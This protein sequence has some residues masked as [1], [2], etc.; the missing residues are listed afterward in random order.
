MSTRGRPWP[1]PPATRGGRRVD[2]RQE[3]P[4]ARREPVADRGALGQPELLQLANVDLERQTRRPE[5]RRQVCGS[6]ARKLTDRAQHG[7]RPR[8]VAAGPIEPRQP[9]LERFDLLCLR[10]GPPQRASRVR[11]GEAQPYPVDGPL[12]PIEQRQH[13]VQR[14]QAGMAGI[15][16]VKGVPIDR[17]DRVEGDHPDRGTL[18]SAGAHARRRPSANREGHPA[19][20]DALEDGA[21]EQHPAAGLMLAGGRKRRHASDA[22]RRPR[23][24][25]RSPSGSSSRMPCALPSATASAKRWTGSDPNSAANAPRSIPSTLRYPSAMASKARVGSSSVSDPATA[26]WPC[27]ASP[28]YA[29][30]SRSFQERTAAPSYE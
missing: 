27:S 25:S 4:S 6:H 12:S 20:A 8:P 1:R 24:V 15:S 22:R 16:L 18:P 23:E 14:A 30:R 26:R 7:V 28:T 2:R 29:S 21:P 5:A 13:L 3:R 19:V 9:P 11:P 17:F 10:H